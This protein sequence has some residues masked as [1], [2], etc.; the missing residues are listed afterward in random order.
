MLR[1]SSIFVV[2]VIILLSVSSGARATDDA[3]DTTNPCV[4]LISCMMTIAGCSNITSMPAASMAQNIESITDA[5]CD[6][7]L[8]TSA[9]IGMDTIETICS[10][11]PAFV[12]A[13]LDTAD[14]DASH[15]NRRLAFDIEHPSL[16]PSGGH[17]THM[18][19]I[20]PTY[21][22]SG[23]DARTDANA[24]GSYTVFVDT[25]RVAFAAAELCV[26]DAAL[27]A[28]G[29]ACAAVRTGAIAALAAAE[30]VCWDSVIH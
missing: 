8:V 7:F 17:R 18:A 20:T 23:L 13:S 4:A 29:G 5:E 6:D 26:A 2:N 3:P 28:T 27:L 22:T 24:V 11:A 10:L 16:L 1:V 9:L 30:I 19:S 25:L 21:I 15:A 14:T 12:A